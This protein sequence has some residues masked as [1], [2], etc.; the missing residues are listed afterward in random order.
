MTPCQNAPTFVDRPLRQSAW[1][2][3]N[4][5]ANVCDEEVFVTESDCSEIDPS[6]FTSAMVDI[7]KPTCPEAMDFEM[8]SIRQNN[9]WTLMKP[10][11]RIKPIGN[12]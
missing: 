7:D 3:I 10:P 11:G 4:P 1:L 6:I 12:K 8:E 9:V 5:K 2:R